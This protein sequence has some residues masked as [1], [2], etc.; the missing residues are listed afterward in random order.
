MSSPILASYSYTGHSADVKMH[1]VLNGRSLSV[2]QL[3]P[4]FLILE[5]PL[6]HPPATAVL[7]FSIDG[8]ERTREVRLP[9][10]ISAGSRRVAIAN[11][12]E[13]P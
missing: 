4:D 13:S 12:A 11:I 5:I 1:L 6:D 2:S 8:N 7:F 3:G 10:G 9:E